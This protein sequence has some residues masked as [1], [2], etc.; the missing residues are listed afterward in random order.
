MIVFSFAIRRKTILIQSAKEKEEEELAQCTFQPSIPR[1]S[2]ILAVKAFAVEYQHFLQ[3]QRTSQEQ[4]LSDGGANRSQEIRTPDQVTNP[5][6]SSASP[7]PGDGLRRVGSDERL[8]RRGI[9]FLLPF[10]TSSGSIFD[11]LT[12]Q[13]SQR[14]TSFS[15]ASTTS[16]LEGTH[17]V[18][19]TPRDTHSDTHSI[20]SGSA[21]KSPAIRRDSMLLRP[22]ISSAMKEKDHEE[23]E[24]GPPP[25]ASVKSVPIRRNSLLFNP[26]E[27]SRAKD[28]HMSPLPHQ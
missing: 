26:T 17:S 5:E 16:F 28:I 7:H 18:H 20:A 14:I 6:G 11:R 2:E 12:R 21:R 1:E 10:F 13:G 23:A 22:T 3:D 9:F 19:L 4:D 25:E 27:S 24:Q 15:E 8:V